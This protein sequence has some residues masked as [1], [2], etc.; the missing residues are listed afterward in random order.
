[1][2]L[3]GLTVCPLAAQAQSPWRFDLTDQEKV[4][5]VTGELAPGIAEDFARFTTAHPQI[6]TV[7]LNP[8]LGGDPREGLMIAAIVAQQKFATYVSEACVACT[9]AFAGSDRRY[10]ESGA[11]L[12]YTNFPGASGG[13][14][15]EAL[16]PKVYLHPFPPEFVARIVATPMRELWFPKACQLLSSGAITGYV[17]AP[18]FS[19]AIEP[20]SATSLE[21]GLLTSPS[22][23]V[24][25]AVLPEQWN[26]LTVELTDGFDAGMT[27]REL[28]AAAIN[29]ASQYRKAFAPYA[30][31]R[32][33]REFFAA[34]L[35]E[36]DAIATKDANAC[37]E[38][39]VG[40]A[41]EKLKSVSDLLAAQY[42]AQRQARMD[43]MMLSVDTARPIPDRHYRMTALTKVADVLGA[44]RMDQLEQLA[45]AQ[46]PAW[47]CNLM[48]DFYREILKLPEPESAAVLKSLYLTRS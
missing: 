10:L 8:K 5:V 4:V 34:V 35:A 26:A 11:K 13:V 22:L 37:G 25:K 39:I 20:V 23:R 14:L 29:R 9:I 31:D 27:L 42:R 45:T 44:E 48:R 1:M 36:A 2:A 7:H 38:Y 41:S 33:L 12:G 21:E 28:R 15:T 43:D 46:D 40:Q 18:D 6:R 19:S 32:P 3:L 24:F 30:A 16:W 47:I 17:E